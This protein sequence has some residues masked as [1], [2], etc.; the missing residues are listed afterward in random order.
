MIFLKW[1]KTNVQRTHWA[2]SSLKITE[3]DFV[4]LMYDGLWHIFT[5]N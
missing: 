3:E 2:E 5:D 1:L 4:A